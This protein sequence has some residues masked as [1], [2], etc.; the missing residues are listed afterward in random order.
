[1]T[2]VAT[3]PSPS[4]WTTRSHT[5]DVQVVSVARVSVLSFIIFVLES[6]N[7]VIHRLSYGAN[8]AFR[9]IVPLEENRIPLTLQNGIIPVLCYTPFIF[10]AYLARRPNTYF[11][12]LLWLPTVITAIVVSAYKFYWVPPEMNVYN[13]A[14]RKL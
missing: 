4:L 6:P 3:S 13:W 10:L 14:Q 11:I 7:L 1:M 5:N 2:D 8:Q 9:A 12:R